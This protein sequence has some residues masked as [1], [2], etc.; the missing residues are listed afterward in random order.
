MSDTLRRFLFDDLDIRGAVVRLDA[1]WQ[2]LMAGRGYPA[3][4]VDLL[5][6]M[7]ATTVLLADNLKQPG[8]LTIQ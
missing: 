1:V 3:P 8:P 7:T 5:G 4:V 2:K 6:Q